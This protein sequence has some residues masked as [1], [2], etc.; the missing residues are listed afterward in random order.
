VDLSNCGRALLVFGAVCNRTCD[1][2]VLSSLSLSFSFSTAC[3]SYSSHNCAVLDG[4]DGGGRGSLKADG[5]LVSDTGWFGDTMVIV[6]VAMLF[7]VI[8]TVITLDNG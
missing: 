6:E 4:V 3:F 7:T 5:I 8:C 1:V 2:W